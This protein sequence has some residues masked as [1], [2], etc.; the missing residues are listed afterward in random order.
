MLGLFDDGHMLY[1]HDRAG[2]PSLA[3]MTEMAIN[4]LSQNP[5]GSFISIEGGRVDHAN[6]AGN[7][8]RTVTDGVAFAEAVQTAIDMTSEE[9]TLIIVTA[10]HSHALAFQGCCGRGTPIT[11]LRME[12]DPTGEMHTGVPTLADDGKPYTV[13]GYLNGAGSILV[14]E[15]EVDED[16]ATPLSVFSG[17]R[18]DLTQEEATDPDYL[19]QA[20]VP[21][22]SETHSD[23]DVAA[24]ARGPWAHLLTGSIEQSVIFHVVHHAVT[25]GEAAAGGTPAQTVSTGA[26]AA[27]PPAD[28]AGP[29]ATT[30]ARPRTTSRVT[31]PTPRTSC[32]PRSM[33]SSARVASRTRTARPRAP[34]RLKAAARRRGGPRSPRGP[35]PLA[36]VCPRPVPPTRG[37]APGFGGRARSTGPAPIPRATPQPRRQCPAGAGSHPGAR[38]PGMARHR[39]PAGGA[40]AKLEPGPGGDVAAP[41]PLERD[42]GRVARL[43]P[44]PDC[45]GGIAKGLTSALVRGDLHQS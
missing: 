4:V 1:E 23:E 8:H 30:R 34:A 44:L 10:D 21:L 15:G 26:P 45:L 7:L 5:E 20:L 32:P 25:G 43:T 29:T 3:E 36:G 12:V 37:R 38:S 6:H 13:A 19:Q 17:S 33:P 14:P 41:F 2:E 31:P 16:P 35:H 28:G 9:D 40:D 24:Y 27:D 18:P 22:G 42:G 11:G 39:P